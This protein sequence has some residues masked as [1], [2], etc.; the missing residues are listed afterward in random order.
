MFTRYLKVTCL[1]V[2]FTTE[3]GGIC[4]QG[5]ALCDTKHASHMPRFVAYL[6]TDKG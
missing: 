3:P 1:A 2:L 4:T 6:L 5:A